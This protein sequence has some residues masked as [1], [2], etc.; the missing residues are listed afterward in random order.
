MSALI[1]YLCVGNDSG[2]KESSHF[3]TNCVPNLFFLRFFDGIFNPFCQGALLDFVKGS[4][5]CDLPHDYLSEVSLL[6][7]DLNVNLVVRE[8]HSI[9]C[10]E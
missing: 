4:V 9:S 1:E 7:K 3:F 5:G 10:L 6:L 2:G 8:E